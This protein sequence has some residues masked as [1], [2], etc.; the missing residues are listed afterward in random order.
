MLCLPKE[1]PVSV[2]GEVLAVAGEPAGSASPEND[3]CG[4]KGMIRSSNYKPLLVVRDVTEPQK[5]LF[6]PF[7][8]GAPAT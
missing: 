2:V 1:P 4:A 7:V 5:L 3:I 8:R 6:R